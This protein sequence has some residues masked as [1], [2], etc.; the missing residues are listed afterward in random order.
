MCVHIQ[1]YAGVFV[2]ERDICAGVCP[3]GVAVVYG[4]LGLHHSEFS[5]QRF[6]ILP[7]WSPEEGGTSEV[8]RGEEQ[9]KTDVRAALGLVLGA[10]GYPKGQV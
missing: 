5:R 4:E 8:Q 1:V 3:T 6:V 7:E 2:L 10:P 9:R